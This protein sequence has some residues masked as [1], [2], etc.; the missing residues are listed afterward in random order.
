MGG[1]ASQEPQDPTHFLTKHSFDPSRALMTNRE[2]PMLGSLSQLQRD[3][4]TLVIHQTHQRH[5]GIFLNI[6]HLATL[7]VGTSVH[8]F[9]AGMCSLFK[10]TEATLLLVWVQK[11]S[12]RSACLNGWIDFIEWLR[13][14]YYSCNCLFVSVRPVLFMEVVF[15][16][17]SLRLYWGFP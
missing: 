12:S 4:C 2:A 8:S 11:T 6:L 14:L 17:C 7:V 16:G 10:K 3:N 13:F 9:T 5:P 1:P 15:H